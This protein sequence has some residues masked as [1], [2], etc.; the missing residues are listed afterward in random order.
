[1]I[2]GTSVCVVIPA[3]DEAGSIAGVLDALP[4]G[5][6]AIVVDNDSRD[7]T[8]DIARQ[9][10]AIV[11]TAARRGYGTAVRTGF[12]ALRSDPPDVVVVL[13]ADHADD[14]A[15]IGRLVDPIARGEAD[16]AIGD[17]SRTAEPGAMT[18]VQRLGNALAVRAIELACGRRFHDLGA[19]RAIRWSCV[20]RLDLVDPT[21]G[22]NVEMNLKAV[23]LGLRIVEIP[24]P[25]RCRRAGRSKISGTIVGSARAG[26]RIARAVQRYR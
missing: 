21:W 8:P 26:Y 4:A 7:G 14:P 1:M 10:G 6:R 25:Y 17:R 5:V 11:V 19:Y 9:H 20:D 23:R 18:T 3:L 13:D 12:A 15:L 22:F 16:L 2:D 24:L